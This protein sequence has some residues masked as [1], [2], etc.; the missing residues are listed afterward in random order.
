MTELK[1]CLFVL[2]KL[3]FIRKKNQYDVV[4]IFFYFIGISGYYVRGVL[5]VLLVSN[6]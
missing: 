2:F 1:A 6:R 3:I 4:S 5:I